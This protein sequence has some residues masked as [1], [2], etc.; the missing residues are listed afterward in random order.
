MATFTEQQ[1]ELKSKALGA[2]IYPVIL[3]IFGAI[4]VVCM[5]I[6]FVPK[7]EPLFEG[8]RERNQLPWVTTVLLALS[9]GLKDYGWLVLIAIF[10][11]VIFLQ[12][13]AQSDAGRK[14]ID[15]WRLKLPGLGGITLS[16]AIARFCRVLG[17]LLHNGVPMLNALRISKDATGNWVLSEAVAR[18]AER[19]SSGK[20]LA[21][22]LAESGYFPMDVIEMISVGEE[23]NNL[24]HVLIQVAEK[25]ERFTQRKLDLAVRLLEPLLLVVMGAMILFVFIGLLLP[26]FKSSQMM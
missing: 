15:R 21:R 23:A 2:M 19:I 18:S 1:E 25:M 20:S 12:Q 10:G 5:L 9:D 8:L 17:T 11:A 16:L 14:E 6:F 22:P 26:I 13:A 7:F 24:E 3:M 4:V